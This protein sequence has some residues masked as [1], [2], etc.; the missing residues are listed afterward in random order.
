MN[1]L[2]GSSALQVKKA[3][4]IL[5]GAVIKEKMNVSFP[6]ISYETETLKMVYKPKDGFSLSGLYYCIM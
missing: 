4:N 5:L 2:R 3:L 6:Y 1:L